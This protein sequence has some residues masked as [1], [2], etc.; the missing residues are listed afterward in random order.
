MFYFVSIV[1]QLSFATVICH[2]KHFEVVPDTVGAGG[3]GYFVPVVGDV[4]VD[5][6]VVEAETLLFDTEIG[7]FR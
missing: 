6:F 2:T 3:E 5:A 4:F 7:L 1:P